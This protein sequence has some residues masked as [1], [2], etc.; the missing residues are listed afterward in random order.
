MAAARAFVRLAVGVSVAAGVAVAARAAGAAAAGAPAPAPEHRL[1]IAVDARVELLSILCR[2]AGY[3]EYAKAASPYARAAD[4]HF[5][6]FA[7]H[8]AVRSTAGLRARWGISYDAPVELALYL[9]AGLA[10]L[11]PLSPLPPG[12]DPRWETAPVDA[13]LGE[14]RAFAAAADFGGFFAAQAPLRAR[15]EAAFR[16]FLHTRPIVPW[17]DGAFGKRARASYLLA[18]GLLTWPMNYGAR[19][20]HAD[21]AEDVVQV[22]F[23]EDADADGVP[24]PT[25]L[26]LELLAHETAH[27]YVNPIF[28]ARAAEMAPVAAPLFARAEKAMHAQHY[29][30]VGIMVNESVVR[31][32]T[33]LYLRAKSTA[34]HAEKSLAEQEKLGFVWTAD[35]LAALE[36]L[37]AGS[38]GKLEAG[39]LFDTTR[40]AFAAW[41]ARH[42]AGR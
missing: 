40:A 9:D 12:L 19:A 11:R 42:P 27:S 28:E 32:V 1:R 10:P 5:A 35:L 13:Y 41:A 24:R 23:L 21:G 7:G 3:P 6:P 8:A 34:G 14:V 33:I 18:P 25:A 26:T 37:R 39:A 2:V 15:V 36:A 16:A 17:F 20:V 30:T 38:G 22:M 4:A 31:A 29:D